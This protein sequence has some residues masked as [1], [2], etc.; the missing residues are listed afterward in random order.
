MT[1]TID[2]PLD[3]LIN[4]PVFASC[5]QVLLPPFNALDALRVRNVHRLLPYHSLID[6]MDVAACLNTM[7]ERFREGSISFH[8][9][10]DEQDILRQ[11][12]KK[13]VGIFFF[14]GDHKAKFGMIC[15]GGGFQYVGSIHEGYPFALELNKM[16]HAA[17]VLHYRVGSQ[18]NALEDL[19]TALTWV[20]EHTSA[21]HIDPHAHSLWGSSAGARMVAM[22]DAYGTAYFGGKETPRAA[23]VILAYTGHDDV[24]GD[25]APTYV[26]VGDDDW[27]A[28]PKLMQKRVD[29]LKKQGTPVVFKIIPGVAHGFGLG[30]KSKAEGWIQE[31]LKYWADHTQK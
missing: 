21:L 2:T 19:A 30:R 29:R 7:H 20:H 13:D 6:P 16:G 14:K 27:I 31:A 11:P 24:T 1:I 10:Y 3:E 23:A 5:Q 18:I 26:I 4:D 25:E 17:F 28:P 9:I 22:V 15:P 8:H 12:R